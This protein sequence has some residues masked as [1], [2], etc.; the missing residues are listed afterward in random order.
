M[1]CV[2]G[3]SPKSCAEVGDV[4]RPSFIS[5]YTRLSVCPKTVVFIWH[6]LRLFLLSTY[7]NLFLP[8]YLHSCHIIWGFFPSRMSGFPS[9]QVEPKGSY[10][11]LLFFAPLSNIFA[12]EQCCLSSVSIQERPPVFL[13]LLSS[14][15]TLFSLYSNS[16]RDEVCFCFCLSKI[17]FSLDDNLGCF[18]LLKYLFLSFRKICRREGCLFRLC[19]LKSRLHYT[20]RSISLKAWSDG[21]CLFL[22]LSA[23]NIIDAGI[24]WEFPG[25]DSSTS[26]FWSSLFLSLKIS[27]GFSS[28][29]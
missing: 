25:Q 14:L 11:W 18:L 4:L 20:Q 17:I 23:Q 8:K 24:C 6:D 16:W 29:T 15:K 19:L 28:K 3:A 2:F 10:V 22:F 27:G 12:E 9:P 5:Q 1:F 21:G 26:G 13:G 7:R